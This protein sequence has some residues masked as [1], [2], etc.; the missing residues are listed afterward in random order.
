MHVFWYDT[1]I[2]LESV[3]FNDL[4][5]TTPEINFV[6][7]FWRDISHAARFRYEHSSKAFMNP[8]VYEKI[9]R[10][11]IGFAPEDVVK[12]SVPYR[13]VSVYA[14]NRNSVGCESYQSILG[15][16]V[17]LLFTVSSIAPLHGPG[18][19][20]T[21]DPSILFDST[22]FPS[23]SSLDTHQTHSSPQQQQSMVQ[24][25]PF[26]SENATMEERE[27]EEEMT[28]AV[29]SS[30]IRFY[31]YTLGELRLMCRDSHLTCSGTKDEVIR[32]LAKFE[33]SRSI[34]SVPRISPQWATRLAQYFG[35][36][37]L[38]SL[39][40][41]NFVAEQNARVQLGFPCRHLY[42]GEHE[43]PAIRAMTESPGRIRSSQLMLRGADSV[44]AVIAANAG[45]LTRMY[46]VG[47][48]KLRSSS[49]DM[50]EQAKTMHVDALYFGIPL[51]PTISS[52]PAVLDI[53]PLVLQDR[54]VPVLTLE[55]VVNNMR[56]WLEYVNLKGEKHI[57]LEQILWAVKLP[58][59]HRQNA[60]C[61][62][63]FLPMHA[64][65]SPNLAMLHQDMIPQAIMSECYVRHSSQETSRLQEGQIYVH[66]A[67]LLEI[68]GAGSTERQQAIDKLS[69]LLSS[70]D[71]LQHAIDVVRAGRDKSWEE[72][73]AEKH[74][75]KDVRRYSWLSN[76]AAQNIAKQFHADNRGTAKSILNRVK[77]RLASTKHYGVNDES[78]APLHSSNNS[79][80]LAEQNE[81]MNESMN[82]SEFLEATYENPSQMN[83]SDVD[84]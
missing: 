14:W 56:K 19:S 66:S 25:A 16:R 1:R 43:L 53:Q 59:V 46:R 4:S 12:F 15:M 21:I 71:L 23:R 80:P 61:L 5:L 11:E 41:N 76:D 10:K 33:N 32:R 79:L 84:S 42:D 34:K 3:Y 54:L 28:P 17:S 52:L 75:V 31:N 55:A 70:P 20:R 83:T 57:P 7:G 50:D 48:I 81:S 60:V 39:R 73:R 24:D 22:S 35:H 72:T 9:R 47:C 18:A 37:L 63:S 62:P 36:V 6:L 30:M 8:D 13:A 77:S 67:L 45:L 58:N 26:I 29:I 2:I 65:V 38:Q 51:L 69:N 68:P 78:I 74:Y 49:K 44:F 82:E 27:I 40:N 64:M